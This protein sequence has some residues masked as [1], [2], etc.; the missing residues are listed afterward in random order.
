MPSENTHKPDKAGEKKTDAGKTSNAV[1]HY[2]LGK[3][4]GE[5]TFGKVKL[6]THIL[7]GEKVAVKVLEKSKIKDKKDVERISRE[8][9]ILKQLHHPNVV[10]IYEII[11]TEKD[12]FLVMEYASGGELF[13]LIVQ[14]QRLKERTASKYFQELVA[15]VHYIHKLGVCHRDLKPENLLIDFD[16]SLK[17][18]DF[19]LSNTYEKG[20]T[21]KTACVSPCYAAPEMIAGNRYH[22]L[23]SDLW[24]CGV[25]L[26]SMLC[27]YLPFED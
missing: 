17:I 15:G 9:K 2:I 21:L 4:L 12:L 11:E 19:G 14:N 13:D 7:S 8:I 25:V 22:G 27:G 18:V 3:A 6:G 1:G 23:K 26:Y 24:S 16:K 5:G 20:Q 10:Q